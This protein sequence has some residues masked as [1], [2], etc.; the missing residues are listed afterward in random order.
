MPAQ[1]PPASGSSVAL[2]PASTA[3]PHRNEQLFSDHFLDQRLPRIPEWVALRAE[4]GVVLSAM[5]TLFE[6][7]R[8]FLPSLVE[9]DLERRFVRPVLEQLGHTFS[10]QASLTTPAGTKRP[11]YMLYRSQAA[12]DAHA[13]QTL[14]E[15]LLRGAAIAVADAKAWG[16]SLDAPAAPA[17]GRDP[18]EASNPSSQIDF[19]I[20]QSG[21]SWGIL[22]DG[23]YWRLYHEDTSK[24]LYRFY[25]IDLAALL[26]TNDVDNFLYFYVFF[27]RAAFEPTPV[28]LAAILRESVEYARGVGASIKE[29]TFA[30]LR[31]MAQGFLDYPQNRLQADDQTLR[32]I[33]DNSLIVL[34]RLLFALY[35]EARG[36]LPLH[37]NQRYRE[38]YSLHSIKRD[39]AARLSRGVSRRPTSSL[40]WG[41]LGSLFTLIDQ[42]DPPLEIATFNGGLFDPAKHPFLEENAVGDE[43][44]ERALDCITRVNGEFVDYRD[45]AT[46]HLGTIYEGLLEYHLAPGDKPDASAPGVAFTVDLLNDKGERKSSGSFYTPDYVVENI[47]RTTLDPIIATA[48]EGCADDVARAQAVLRLNVV[49]PAMGSAHFLVEATE[50]L[51]RY[52]ATLNVPAAAMGL[53]TDGIVDVIFWKRRVAQACIYGVDLNPL[54]VEL[55]KVSLWLTTAVKDRPLSFL[56]HHLRCGNSLIGADLD[57]VSAAKGGHGGARRRSKAVHADQFT[58]LEEPGWRDSIRDAVVSMTFIES[59]PGITVGDVKAQERAYEELHGKLVEKFGAALN[60]VAALELGMEVDESLRSTLVEFA[61]SG[62]GVLLRQVRKHMAAAAA[63]AEEQDFFHWEIEFPDVYFSVNGERLGEQAGFDAVIGNPPY[64]REAGN[65]EKFRF[66]QRANAFKQWYAGKTDLYF[67][68]IIQGVR[69]LHPGGRLG[70]ITPAQWLES[71]SAA[72]LQRFLRTEAWPRTIT[73]FDGRS[74]FEEAAVEPLILI[75]ERTTAGQSREEHEVPSTTYRYP[76]DTDR[77]AREALAAALEVDVPPAVLKRPAGWYLR[78]LRAAGAEAICDKVTAQAGRK[79]LDAFFHVEAGVNTGADALSS[80]NEEAWPVGATKGTGIF[81]LSE[82]EV[83][84]LRLTPA[85][86]ALLKRFV[87]PEG[88]GRYSE[89][90]DAGARLLYLTRRTVIDRF[91]RVKRHLERFRIILEQRAEI[92]RNPGGREWWHL[93]WPREPERFDAPEKLVIANATAH[94]AFYLD[95][96]QT[97]YNIG[98][99]VLSPKADGGVDPWYALAVLNSRLYDFY[100]GLRGQ[101]QSAGQRKYFPKK[102]REIPLKVS[103]GQLSVT[104]RQQVERLVEAW[105]AGAAGGDAPLRRLTGAR[106]Q[107]ALAPLA[108]AMQAQTAVL[109]EAAAALRLEL[110]GVLGGA[111]QV[112]RLNRLWTPKRPAAAASQAASGQQVAGVKRKRTVTPTRSKPD[113]SAILGDL[114]A[115]VLEL[116]TDFV[117]LTEPQWRFLALERLG[118]SPHFADVVQAWRTAKAA[119]INAAQ[120]REATDALI[121]DLVFEHYR[122]TVDERALVMAAS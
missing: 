41:Q 54:A 34:Y 12:A 40:L 97:Y 80:R 93:L 66:V 111:R 5:R 101:S 64:I 83:A 61:I 6:Q 77:T 76:R 102:V 38:D 19:Y 32:A 18:F 39:V 73:V 67:Y 56:D 92:V 22:T 46:R 99:T 109:K 84:S 72:K 3:R 1:R 8:H 90:D 103:R 100:Y 28:G 53:G 47:V 118:R 2:T 85:E 71:V 14:T 62:K 15:D 59:S 16:R 60:S 21:V 74:V 108:Q 20:R 105:L 86:S 43:Y 27:R 29:Q 89:T 115:E 50:Y 75:C 33:Y 51:A 10:V 114:S 30:A 31:L 37:E 107:C 24:K 69:L 44:L 7:H 88:V 106:L 110:E 11:D 113:P 87:P 121:D 35:A 120:Q 23:R 42:G 70:F 55:G 81:L 78:P 79:T 91:P 68:F 94:N 25:E 96:Q 98:C 9:A 26:D 112:A 104:D 36:L 4:A 49:D 58:F 119:A 17:A 45:L 52:L 122:F 63:M 48:T 95:T 13:G 117:R 116:D 65:K 57:G 82:Q